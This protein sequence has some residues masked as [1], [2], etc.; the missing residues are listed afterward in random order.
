MKQQRVG[1]GARKKKKKKSQGQTYLNANPARQTPGRTS[2]LTNHIQMKPSA[3]V[4]KLKAAE[5]FA[6]VH[7]QCEQLALQELNVQLE[8]VMLSQEG[9]KKGQ[10]IHFFWMQK[11]ASWGR[12]AD[13]AVR[14]LSRS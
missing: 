3:S 9:K 10:K 11:F 14:G 4:S 1:G 6:A 2:A 8:E 13:I 7:L 5:D 12:G